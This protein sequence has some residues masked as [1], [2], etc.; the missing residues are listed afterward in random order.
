MLVSLHLVIS[1]KYE[2]Y[3]LAIFYLFVLLKTDE[4]YIQI[5]KATEAVLNFI[6]STACLLQGQITNKMQ[7]LHQLYC[8]VWFC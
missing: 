5:T 7:Q 2:G 1:S 6:S 8:A 4:R 3:K